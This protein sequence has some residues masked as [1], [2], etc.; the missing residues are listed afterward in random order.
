MNKKHDWRTE[1]NMNGNKLGNT[2]DIWL[3]NTVLTRAPLI[4]STLGQTSNPL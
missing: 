4:M 2:T 1:K 3:V